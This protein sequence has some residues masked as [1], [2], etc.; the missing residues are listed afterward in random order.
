[1][2]L[3][4]ILFIS[5]SN[6]IHSE[7]WRYA[8]A[9]ITT[10][11]NTSHP[12]NPTNAAANVGATRLNTRGCVG[13]WG[14]RLRWRGGH[15]GQGDTGHD[16]TNDE[17]RRREGDRAGWGGAV[18]SAQRHCCL[19][20]RY[21]PSPHFP[22]LPSLPP[23]FPLPPPSSHPLPSHPFI[24]SLLPLPPSPSSPFPLSFPLPPPF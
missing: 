23:M 2:R 5:I 18:A 13:R 16:D 1:M 21:V 11:T 8:T 22:S 10:P 4:F 6:Y 19:P 17:S 7:P 20:P 14:R 3:L 24:S 15:G 9:S 12:K